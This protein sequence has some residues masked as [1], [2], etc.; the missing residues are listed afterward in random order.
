M[1]LFIAFSGS[2]VAR[3]AASMPAMVADGDFANRMAKR[4]TPRIR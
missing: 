2:S 4:R 1:I 3:I